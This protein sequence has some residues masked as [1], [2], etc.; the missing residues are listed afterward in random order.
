M[1]AHL[2]G[3]ARVLGKDNEISLWL[4][5][6]PDL[7]FSQINMCVYVFTC[8]WLLLVIFIFIPL[9]N[10]LCYAVNFLTTGIRARDWLQRDSL[11]PGV[12]SA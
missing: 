2:V 7:G 11:M 10:Y 8:L 9:S 3:L 6:S 5:F 4:G 12:Y 1:K